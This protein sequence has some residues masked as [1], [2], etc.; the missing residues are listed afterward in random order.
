AKYV[1]PFAFKRER[2]EERRI[3]ELRSR[4]GDNCRRCR[5]PIRFD[6]IRGHDKGPAIE[7]VTSDPTDEPQRL[8]N[9]CLCHCRCNADSGDNTL[10]VTERVRRK[11][12]AEL[13]VKSR[14]VSKAG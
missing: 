2:E 12:E 1:T 13:F 3:V 9:L 7:P 14:P 8:E 5:R 6:L 10:E 4:D 11:S